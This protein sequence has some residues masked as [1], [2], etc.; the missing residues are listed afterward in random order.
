MS[1]P[2]ISPGKRLLR[3]VLAAAGLGAAAALWAED[4]PAPEQVDELTEVIVSVPEPRYVAP[5]QRDRI[6]RVWVPVTIN[7]QGPF[8]LVL[9]SGA[10]RTAVN[11]RVAQALG[12]PL[13]RSPPVMLRGVTGSA[14][15]PTIEVDNISV[16]DLSVGPAVLPIVADA[17]GGAEGLLGMYGMENKRIYIDFRNDFINV[18][19]SRNRR[20]D[21]GFE[22]IP[23]IDDPL[24][25]LVVR[26]RIGGLPVRAIIDT[27]AQT[28]F[29]N[30]ALRFALLRQINRQVP[31]KD[32]I[33]GATG[34]TQTGLGAQIAR[35]G[36][37]SI[38]VR[39]AHVTFGDMHI[40]ER[41]NIGDE[42]ALV[43]GMD[44]LGL[45][46]T[47]V[48]DY[49]RRELHIKPRRGK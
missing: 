48:I 38:E 41:W 46:D 21:S 33:T 2:T 9:D 10:M 14:V 23:F 43:I 44:V 20:A 26:A 3:I 49:H 40:F 37:G 31:S 18:S 4:A 30:E 24:Q 34:D 28:T 19:L 45:V 39:D 15:A 27:G 17:F 11:P 6:G 25:L 5:T 35:I 47:L 29:G 1:Y 7:G 36:L 16:G 8:R 13:D 32:E 22:V 42:P 12:I